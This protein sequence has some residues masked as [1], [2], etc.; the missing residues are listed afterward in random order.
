MNGD[1]AHPD[2]NLSCGHRARTRRPADRRTR[3][4]A[5]PD[6]I[7]TAI[8][9]HHSTWAM[10]EAILRK[11]GDSENDEL[12]AS[13]RRVADVAADT[14][15]NIRPTTI[16]GVIELLDYAYQHESKDMEC[17][18]DRHADYWTDKP[19]DKFGIP[20]HVYLCKHAAS[21]LAA[22]RRAG[23]SVVINS[24]KNRSKARKG[25]SS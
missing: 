14:L 25:A 19:N 4:G 18:P 21:A 12:I 23:G 6:P 24:S 7:F 17:F 10:F 9:H 5:Q 1:R 11:Y 15:L 16:G 20:F 22:I 13:A 2:N 8:E 3:N